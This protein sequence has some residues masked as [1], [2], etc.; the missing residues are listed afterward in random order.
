VRPFKLLIGLGIVW[1]FA[2]LAEPFPLPQLELNPK[3]HLQTK[4]LKVRADQGFVLLAGNA[5]YEVEIKATPMKSESAARQLAKVELG[6][7]KSLYGTRG[8]PYAG[9]I[10]DTIECEKAFMPR[11]KI[12][13]IG[14]LTVEALSAG[15]N[16][17]KLFGAC[18]HDQ[19][20]YWSEYFNFYDQQG[21]RSVSVRVFAKGPK[22]NLRNLNRLDQALNSFTSQLLVDHHP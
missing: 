1:P 19:I 18:N 22:P 14:P 16:S 3:L 10:S 21:L 7:I 8:S 13:H 5:D 11:T 4:E 15:A 17:R 20:E 12:T 6:N 2:V 9:Q